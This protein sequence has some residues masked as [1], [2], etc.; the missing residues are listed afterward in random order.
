MYSWLFQERANKP[1]KDLEGWNILCLPHRASGVRKVT[2]I[3]NRNCCRFFG[4]V[5]SIRRFFAK[6]CDSKWG[7]L[8]L[9]TWTNAFRWY[10]NWWSCSSSKESFTKGSWLFDAMLVRIRATITYLFQ[11]FPMEALLRDFNTIGRGSR[12]EPALSSYCGFRPAF[13]E[14]LLF[15][16]NFV[17][18][19]SRW[20][21][22]KRKIG[23][24]TLTYPG[25]SV[26]WQIAE[27]CSRRQY[28]QRGI[29]QKECSLR[30]GTYRSAP[31][32]AS[33]CNLRENAELLNNGILHKIS[34]WQQWKK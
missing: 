9:Q 24:F 13:S 26:M 5:W 1:Q 17:R 2:D 16:S 25:F 19:L 10:H 27:V 7:W 8:A 34:T 31:T 14:T 15:A 3:R 32:I 30:Y 20:R 33:G 22:K 29:T 4:C 12:F 28:S 6:T 21:R 23:F 18:H 11:I